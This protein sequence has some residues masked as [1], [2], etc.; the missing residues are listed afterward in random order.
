MDKTASKHFSQKLQMGSARNLAAMIPLW[1]HTER[2]LLESFRPFLPKW[3]TTFTFGHF[4]HFS[5]Q[6]W[7]FFVN[8]FRT[9]YLFAL[10]LAPFWYFSPFR[11]RDCYSALYCSTYLSNFVIYNAMLKMFAASALNSSNAKGLGN[12]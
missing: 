10:I 12:T 8:N 7:H 1:R 4:F 2:P 5:G 11:F 6:N 3:R 9:E